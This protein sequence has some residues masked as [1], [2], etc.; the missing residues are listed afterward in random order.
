MPVV[1]TL[2]TPFIKSGCWESRT[3]VIEQV[4]LCQ[5]AHLPHKLVP[6]YPEEVGENHVLINRHVHEPHA[7][8]AIKVKNISCIY[9]F[10]I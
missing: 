4:R 1:K 10:Y 3:F 7:I 2:V 5:N 9:I 6:F 8:I